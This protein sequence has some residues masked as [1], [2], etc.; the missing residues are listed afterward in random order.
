VASISPR[1]RT[2]PLGRRGSGY[3]IAT[4]CN[5]VSLS[6]FCR[7]VRLHAIARCECYV[8]QLRDEER[9][10]G[11]CRACWSIFSC[12]DWRLES[13]DC[14]A[15]ARIAGRGRGLP[16]EG[17]ESRFPVELTSLSFLWTAN[18]A[19]APFRHLVLLPYVAIAALACLK[20]SDPLYLHVDPGPLTT[21]SNL[22]ILLA[23]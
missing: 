1:P 18:G 10:L 22:V 17:K 15:R 23:D 16:G 13:E 8:A 12:C 2:S 14:R 5:L 19:M 9:V 21:S 4:V 7:G 11:G 20:T 6:F 3:A